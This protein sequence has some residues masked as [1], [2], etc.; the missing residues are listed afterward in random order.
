L[1][2]QLTGA[3]IEYLNAKANSLDRGDALITVDGANLQ[4]ELEQFMYRLFDL[5]QIRA[6]EEGAEFLL[7]LG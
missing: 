1:Q 5:I 7:G 3:Q 2:K 4:L 6:T